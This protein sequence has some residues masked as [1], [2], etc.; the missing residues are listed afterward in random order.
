MGF[1][2]KRG[3]L[4]VDGLLIVS[5]LTNEFIPLSFVASLCISNSKVEN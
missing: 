5:S 4:S 3:S 2:N 1:K